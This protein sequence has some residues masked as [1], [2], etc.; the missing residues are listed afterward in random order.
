[1]PMYIVR[2]MGAGTKDGSNYGLQQMVVSAA[3]TEE[4]RRLGAADLGTSPSMV[5]VHSYGGGIQ[6]NRRVDTSGP[7][8]IVKPELG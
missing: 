8:E 2:R 1:M 3:N 4:A 5:T 7:V 6:H